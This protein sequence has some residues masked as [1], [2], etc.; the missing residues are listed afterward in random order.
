MHLLGSDVNRDLD[1]FG[2]HLDMLAG[3]VEVQ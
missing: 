3:T 1:D 2:V